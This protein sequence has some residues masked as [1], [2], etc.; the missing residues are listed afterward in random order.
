MPRIMHLRLWLLATVV[1]G[2]IY[3]RGETA[4]IFSL[5]SKDRSF[6]EFA[7]DRPLGRSVVYRVGES[8]PDKDWYAYQPGSFDSMVGISVPERDWVPSKPLHGDQAPESFQ[9]LFTLSSTPKGTFVLHLSAIF[10]Y[11]RPAAPLYAVL[12]NGVHAGSYRLAPRPAPELWWP[13]GGEDEGNLQFIGYQSLDMQLPASLFSTGS[14]TLSMQCL[15]GFGI[16]LR[17]SLAYK[18]PGD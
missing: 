10:H 6:T 11:W 18:R 12:I 1:L 17:S 9:I 4:E 8:L 13:T 3:A 14:N 2:G 16:L 5:G 7:R 15:D